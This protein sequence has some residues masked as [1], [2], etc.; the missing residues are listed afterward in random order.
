[1]NRIKFL[2]PLRCG[3]SLCKLI[4]GTSRIFLGILFAAGM[5]LAARPAIAQNTGSIFGSVQD[6]SGAVIPGAV[7]T[8]ADPAHAVSRAVKSNGSGEFTIS[9][10]PIGTYTLTTTSP[11][12]Q[13]SV[14][15]GIHV[16][17]NADIKK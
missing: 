16:D 14:V 2:G 17:A 10:L 1:M 12:F 6:P 11:Q 9:A 5:M 8:A 4:P 3:T 13:N 15:T 7:I